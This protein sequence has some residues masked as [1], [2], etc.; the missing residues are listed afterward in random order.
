MKL[1]V[2]KRDMKI[3]IQHV[4]MFQAFVRHHSV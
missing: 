3:V 1:N 2:Y 4:K